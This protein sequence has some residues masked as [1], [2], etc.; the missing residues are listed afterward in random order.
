[1]R[2]ILEN[3]LKPLLF[4]AILIISAVPIGAADDIESQKKQAYFF[5]FVFL[6]QAQLD[7]QG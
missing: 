7:A 3:L 5:D 6:D 1:M 4:L 2:N